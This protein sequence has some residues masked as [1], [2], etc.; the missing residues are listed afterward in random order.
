MSNTLGIEITRLLTHYSI[1]WVNINHDIENAIK[2][3]LSVLIF[4]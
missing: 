1:Y 3:T 4:R 2:T